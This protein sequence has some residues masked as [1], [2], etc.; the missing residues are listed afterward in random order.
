MAKKRS[1]I[2]KR[3][4]GVSRSRGTART[5]SRRPPPFKMAPVAS[6]LDS[7][8]VAVTMNLDFGAAA[9]G[10]VMSIRRIDG[11]ALSSGRAA[12]N[13]GTHT[14]GWDVLSPTVRPLSFGVT[15]TEDATGKT[16]L[17]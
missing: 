7:A 4:H 2:S 10:D 3:S 8:S 16:L 5:R 12:V 14:V 17:S 9:P 6:A 15:V 13:A 1:K 11:H